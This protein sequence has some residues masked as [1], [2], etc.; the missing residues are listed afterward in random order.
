MIEVNACEASG[1]CFK[2]TIN[3]D[4]YIYEKE[5]ILEYILHQKKEITLQL[6]AYEKQRS[7]LKTEQE[8]LSKAAKE[9]QVKGFLEK[10]MS[11][12][13]KPLNPLTAV[14]GMNTSR[15]ETS[16]DHSLKSSRRSMPCLA[17]SQ[18]HPQNLNKHSSWL[19]PNR[20]SPQ[21]LSAESPEIHAEQERE[22]GRDTC[23]DDSEHGGY[24]SRTDQSLLIQQKLNRQKTE[25]RNKS[26]EILSNWTEHPV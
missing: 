18:T 19:Q 17:Q 25:P 20:I 14:P 8:E 22:A 5:A 24:D 15:S 4:G 11:I 3:P 16:K 7:E 2:W 23:T 9:S 6:K 1:R 13:L 26:S 21:P 10:E 12:V